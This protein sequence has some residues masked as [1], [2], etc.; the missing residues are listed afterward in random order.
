MNTIPITLKLNVPEFGEVCNRILDYFERGDNRVPTTLAMLL[1]GHVEAML[2]EA[3]ADNAKLLAFIAE[4]S[5][6][7]GAHHKQ[8]VIDQIVRQVAPGKQ[9]TQFRDQ[10]PDWDEG[11]AP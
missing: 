9:Y 7:D 1:L 8:W 2:K 3:N 10:N 5:D 11:I 4:H 6:I